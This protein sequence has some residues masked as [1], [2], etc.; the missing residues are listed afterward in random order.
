MSRKSDG[1]IEAASIATST[2]SSPKEA[3]PAAAFDEAFARGYNKVKTAGGMPAPALRDYLEFLVSPQQRD[4]L[5]G[6]PLTASASEVARKDKAL[7][8]SFSRGFGQ[9][10]AGVESV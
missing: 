1:L 6:C 3:V 2:S 8:A 5:A 4:N 9:R 7:S 10:A